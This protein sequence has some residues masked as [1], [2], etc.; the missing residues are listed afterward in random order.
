[1]NGG[2]GRVRVD[3]VDWVGAALWAAVTAMA[4]AVAMPAGAQTLT[5]VEQSLAGRSSSFATATIAPQTALGPAGVAGQLR[6]GG[7]ISSF[8][9]K[10]Q[11]PETVFRA[12]EVPPARIEQ[13]RV[14][15]QSMSARQTREAAI[16]I[17]LPAD[18]LFDFDK[19]ELRADAKEPL[20][21]AADLLRSYREAPVEI[22]GHTDS[23]GSD[24]YN[25][26]LSLRRAQTVARRL[27]ELSGGRDFKVLGFGERQPIVPN[28]RLD[29]S[30]DPDGRQRNRRVAIVIEPR[31]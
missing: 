15:L 4:V 19:S 21:K 13:T 20:A 6:S 7:P 2:R 16:V 22:Q 18:V 31:R 10:A 11:A 26:A 23:M 17:D 8:G 5:R 29:G 3:A 28:A 27:G 25:D 12:A 9:A 30:D 24:S 14:L 1:M